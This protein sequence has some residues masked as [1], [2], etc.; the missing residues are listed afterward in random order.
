MR[1]GK[2]E[3]G[4]LVTSVIADLAKLSARRFVLGPLANALTG[5]LSGAFSGMFGSAAPMT[6]PMPVPRPVLHRGGIA[7]GAAPLRRIPDA[8]FLAAPRL[9][10]G[11]VAGLRADEAPAI[12]QRGERVL[13]RAETRAY[14]QRRE[15]G[16]VQ[17]TIVARDTESFR[18]SRT[19]VA[20]DIARAVL[21]R[22]PTPPTRSPRNSTPRSGP[23]SAPLRAGRAICSTP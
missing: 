19:Q 18:Q 8:A 3:V 23:R 12:L 4:S 13:S 17:I 22:A 9:H 21:A 10:R 11:G 14:D 16:P 1:T 15:P 7:G 6:S 20:A 2:V 5:A